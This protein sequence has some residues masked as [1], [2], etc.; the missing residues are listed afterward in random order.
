MTKPT[1]LIDGDQFLYRG[2]IA[3]EQEVKWDSENWVLFSNEEDAHKTVLRS[4]EKLTEKFDTDKVR[5][6]FSEGVSFRKN[7]FPDYKTNRAETRK[8]MCYFQVRERIMG[9]F[10]SLMVDGLEADDLLGI[11]ATRDDGDY[12]I[13]SQD[14]DLKTIP[15]TRIYSGSGDEVITTTQESADYFWLYQTLIGD[16]ADGYP[17]CPGIGPKK[18]EALLEKMPDGPID[19]ETSIIE[20][21]WDLIVQA[22][23]KQG[24]TEDDALMQARCARI[25]RA[26]DW[27][28]TNKEVILW[29]PTSN[30]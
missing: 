29:T 22:Y 25:L 8:P 15:N 3:V 10:P 12:V 28:A 30:S 16:T 13:I 6:A 18:A 5:I 2:C 21:R 19:P 1:L 23:Q 27:D 9:E 7:L 20:W 24:L 14:K 17:G 11:W 26:S 4:F